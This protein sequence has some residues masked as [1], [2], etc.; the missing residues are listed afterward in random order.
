MSNFN[1]LRCGFKMVNY[2]SSFKIL[3]PQMEKK[4]GVECPKSI[5]VFI[6]SCISLNYHSSITCHILRPQAGSYD[7]R[8]SHNP[9]RL[10]R[11]L[12]IFF[13]RETCASSEHVLH[14]E[15]KL[16]G[17]C[18]HLN[19]SFLWPRSVSTLVYIGS[20]KHHFTPLIKG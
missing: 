13:C 4:M 2:I 18:P 12:L 16:G 6:I 3:V 14:S 15:A 9:T 17:I 11:P 20:G 10:S 5:L 1:K 8:P 19:G 7:S